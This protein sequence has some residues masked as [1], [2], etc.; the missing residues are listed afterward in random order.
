M[1]EDGSNDSG[2]ENRGRNSNADEICKIDMIPIDAEHDLRSIAERMVTV[3]YGKAC[4]QIYMLT[5][6]SVIEECLYK[7][8]VEQLSKSHLHKTEGAILDSK[9]KTWIRTMKIAVRV[10]FASEK[11]LFHGIFV[12]F[13]RIMDLCFAEVAKEP[14]MKLLGFGESLG[15]G[16]KSS[17]RLFGALDMYDSLSKLMPDIDTVFFQE[18]CVGRRTQA[19]GV[20]IRLG[21][22][23]QGIF[24]EFKNAVHRENSKTPIPSRIIHPPYKVCDELSEFYVGLQGGP[25]EDYS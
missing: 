9:I 11:H 10:L 8:G 5:R 19:S 14:T 17:D 6:K 15:M 13:N 18:C 20:L 21:K 24:I 4:V 22:A 16:R 23:A 25:R 3:G 1:E 7:I 12:G 2:S